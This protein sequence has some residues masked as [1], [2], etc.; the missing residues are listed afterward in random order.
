[1]HLDQPSRTAFG[2]IKHAVLQSIGLYFPEPDSNANILFLCVRFGGRNFLCEEIDGGIHSGSIKPFA[3]CIDI[4]QVIGVANLEIQLAFYEVLARVP[5]SFNNDVP[6][7]GLLALRDLKRE[8]CS[9]GFGILGDSKCDRYVVIALAVIKVF[10]SFN[11][12][13]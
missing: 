1:M 6:D 9:G 7:N 2:I 10:N 5:V 8:I 3:G 4:R 11:R 13:P 12:I